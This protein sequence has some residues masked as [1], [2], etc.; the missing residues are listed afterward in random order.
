MDRCNPQ[1]PLEITELLEQVLLHLDLRKILILQRVNRFW[2]NTISGSPKLQQELFFQPLPPIKAAQRPPKFNQLAKEPFPFLFE[3]HWKFAAAHMCKNM[4]DDTILYWGSDVARREAIFRP[5][6]SW[7]RMLPVQP[8]APIEG[9]MVE[10]WID[11]DEFS[12]NSL[13]WRQVDASR[14]D[15]ALRSSSNPGR[16]ATM[17]LLYDIVLHNFSSTTKHLG[18]YVQWNMLLYTKD[19]YYGYYRSV[20]PRN[21]ITIHISDR[22]CTR[23]C[24]WPVIS[25]GLRVLVDLPAGVVQEGNKAN[26]YPLAN[27][28]RLYQEFG[29]VAPEARSELD[30][31][32]GR[33]PEPDEEREFKDRCRLWELYHLWKS[34]H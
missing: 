26:R 17:G 11:I 29:R 21:T 3:R 5:G 9:V 8:A 16:N 2:F 27:L 6:A 22:A 23:G 28:F 32:L 20:E 7:R 31:E 19:L 15:S 30:I 10:D 33:R 34:Y 13:E 14:H 18:V 4:V 1:S 12:K 24:Q 25:T